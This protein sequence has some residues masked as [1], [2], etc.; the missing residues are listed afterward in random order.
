MEAVCTG[1]SAGLDLGMARAPLWHGPLGA[2][3]LGL[4]WALEKAGG[5]S[6]RVEE[7]A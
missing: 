3:S 1:T 4:S 7:E 5:P 2:S 6:D